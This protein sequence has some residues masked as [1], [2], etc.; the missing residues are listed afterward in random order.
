M[1]RRGVRSLKMHLIGSALESSKAIA[2]WAY[3]SQFVSVYY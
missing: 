1:D 2:T 3:V